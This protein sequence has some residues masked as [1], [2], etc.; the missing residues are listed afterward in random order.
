MDLERMSRL[1][2]KTFVKRK[3]LKKEVMD[4]QVKDDTAEFIFAAKEQRIQWVTFIT[5]LEWNNELRTQSDSLLIMYD[6]MIERLKNK[7]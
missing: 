7:Q 6:Q 2:D 3:H 4:N 5:S 1:S